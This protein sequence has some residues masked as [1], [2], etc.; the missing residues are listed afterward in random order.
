MSQSDKDR[1]NGYFIEPRG[2]RGVFQLC[3][4]DPE[5]G[6]IKRESL[7]TADRKTARQALYAR[8]GDP[9]R[10]TS[11]RDARLSTVLE[12]YYQDYVLLK[13]LPSAH[14]QRAAARDALEIWGDIDVSE[15]LRP[16]QLELIKELRARRYADGT[17]NGR[18]NR[19]WAALY[20]YQ[21]DHAN[22]LIP[23]RI[24]ARNW[25]PKA[26]PT[27]QPH[28]IDELA[29]LLNAAADLEHCWRF[30]LLAIG[31]ASRE[32]AL[33]E[34]TWQQVDLE[35]GYIRLRP[36]WRPETK[37]RR[38]ILPIAPTLAAELRSWPQTHEHVITYAGRPL[39]SRHFYDGLARRAR[40]RG[41][42][43][44]VRHT[45]RTWLARQGVETGDADMFVGHKPPGS[46]TGQI[47]I[48]LEPDYLRTCTAAIEQLFQE[49]APRVRR[50]FATIGTIKS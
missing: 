35:V 48:H 9:E 42:A 36:D 46:S 2:K 26:A 39:P 44:I 45:I 11:G 41:T 49:L 31:T 21:E 14:V 15:L 50:P 47:Y 32:A 19:I 20:W 1:A 23:T 30:L 24:L 17:I 7:H 5:T 43:H 6:Q 40:V 22:L 38:P 25:D 16:K 3:W 4:Y 27:K 29:T 33:R 10:Y 37:K 34:L 12:A 13:D 18:L 8:A 28:K